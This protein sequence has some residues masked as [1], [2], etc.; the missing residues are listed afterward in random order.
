MAALIQDSIGWRWCFYIQAFMIL[1]GGVGILIIPQKYMDLKNTG[2][3]IRDFQLEKENNERLKRPSIT[4]QKV[5]EE[6]LKSN[7]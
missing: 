1:P 3:L 7:L 5:C 6:S 4:V 2:K